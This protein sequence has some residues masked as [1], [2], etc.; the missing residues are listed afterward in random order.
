M[1]N[2]YTQGAIALLTPC[3]AC[4]YERGLVIIRFPND[5]GFARCGRCD[6]ALYSLGD[7]QSG[8]VTA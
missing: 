8:E 2:P 1:N 7:R 3:R 4:S 6:A 5:K